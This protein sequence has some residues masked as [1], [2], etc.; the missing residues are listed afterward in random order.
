MHEFVVQRSVD[1]FLLL[2]VS[3]ACC[4]VAIALPF[5]LSMVTEGA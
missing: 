1:Q 3:V 5:F 4:S 2:I